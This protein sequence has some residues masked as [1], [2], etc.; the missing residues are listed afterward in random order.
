MAAAKALGRIFPAKGGK[1]IPTVPQVTDS[2][3]R[4]P[5]MPNLVS[6]LMAKRSSMGIYLSDESLSWPLAAAGRE[7]DIARAYDAQISA[8]LIKP[9]GVDEY[10]AAVRSLKEL[11]LHAAAL[12]PRQDA[13]ST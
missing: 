2:V 12:T 7:V 13:A 5:V 3:P 6:I 9:P 4:M 11:W 10:F 1:C 8:Y